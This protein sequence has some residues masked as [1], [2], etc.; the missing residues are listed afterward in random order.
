MSI[1][2]GQLQ[3][4]VR[5]SV[6]GKTHPLTAYIAGLAVEGCGETVVDAIEDLFTSAQAGKAARRLE[7]EIR[8]CMP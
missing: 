4:I 8:E 3:I 7:R 2:R 1:P 6:Q 5:P